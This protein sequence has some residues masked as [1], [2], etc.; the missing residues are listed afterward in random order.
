VQATMK[1]KL[2]KDILPYRILGVCNPSLAHRAFSAEPSIGLLQ[3]C[4]VV[5]RQEVNG[6]VDVEFMDPATVLNLVD[7]LGIPSLA[8]EMRECLDRILAAL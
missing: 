1:K 6:K 8:T 2:G 7:N 4:N 5:V 3:P